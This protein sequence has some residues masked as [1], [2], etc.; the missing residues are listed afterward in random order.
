MW[1]QWNIRFIPLAAVFCLSLPVWAADLNIAPAASFTATPDRG[2]APLTAVLDGGASSDSDGA[3]VQYDWRINNGEILSLSTDT[4]DFEVVEASIDSVTVNNAIVTVTRRALRV[5][6]KTDGVYTVSLTVKDNTGIFSSE[7][8]RNV[9]IG[10][11]NNHYTLLF[12]PGTGNFSSV[13]NS[14]AS[15]QAAYA[16]ETGR[17]VIAALN[18]YRGKHPS[19][20]PESEMDAHVSALLNG[21]PVVQSVIYSPGKFMRIKM[22]DND[23][24]EKALR[25]MEFPFKFESSIGKWVV[26]MERYPLI[27]L[28]SIKEDSI[29]LLIKSIS[30]YCQT[31]HL[32]PPGISPA[33]PS[34]LSADAWCPAWHDYPEFRI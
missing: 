4:T 17:Q 27:A 14:R 12:S 6:F 34:P 26:D 22:H 23:F 7:T 15:M 8:S 28:L 5:K 2:S 3:V 19:P 18:D 31:P 16:L 11:C 13:G 29:P 9:N 10:S 33:V 25:G 30:L 20:M 32:I 1:K 21:D 24:V